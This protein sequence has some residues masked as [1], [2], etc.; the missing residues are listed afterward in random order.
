MI[1]AQGLAGS[2][3]LNCGGYG[4]PRHR[5]DRL[6]RQAAAHPVFDQRHGGAAPFYGKGFL[7]EVRRTP[8]DPSRGGDARDLIEQLYRGDAGA[9]DDHVLVC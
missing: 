3:H 2:H 1:P 5:N 7:S 8:G 6:G 4:Q 9:D